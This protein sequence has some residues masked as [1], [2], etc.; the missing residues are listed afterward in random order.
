MG[1][2]IPILNL[3]TLLDI[4]KEDSTILSAFPTGVKDYLIT[5]YRNKFPDDQ[6]PSDLKGDF[7]YL[8]A[9]YTW[10]MEERLTTLGLDVDASTLL[11]DISTSYETPDTSS[12]DEQW[13][14]RVTYERP[15]TDGY[16][17]YLSSKLDID[18]SFLD[19]KFDL[20]TE[21][22]WVDTGKVTIFKRCC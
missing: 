3:K 10:W 5:R 19:D 7:D 16:M 13:S 4:Y 2:E 21:N 11:S 14:S 17:R 20:W 18:P 9:T 8:F 22:M 12:S 15:H 6:T 1:I